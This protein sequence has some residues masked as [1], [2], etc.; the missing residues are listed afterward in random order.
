MEGRGPGW[1]RRAG[2]LLGRARLPPAGRAGAAPAGQP[3]L[4]QTGASLT[5]GG[6]GGRGRGEPGEA[7][8]RPGRS[9]GLQWSR[10]PE[11]PEQQPRERRGLERLS[12]AR[13]GPPAPELGEPP[14]DEAEARRKAAEAAAQPRAGPSAAAA[15]RGSRARARGAGAWGEAR[16]SLR[17]A[18]VGGHPRSLP[19]WGERPCPPPPAPS[20]AV[21]GHRVR[22]PRSRR[23]GRPGGPLPP[24]PRWQA[25]AHPPASPF[26][27][28]GKGS[29]TVAPF[30]ADEQ[31]PPVSSPGSYLEAGLLFLTV[32]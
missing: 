5:R 23:G 31:G 32:E 21:R 8:R 28:A 16:D 2:S 17:A 25:G 7:E 3:Q 13:P 27:A 30:P 10:S 24:P 29:L 12:A 18:G 20:A 22:Q 1:S 14:G 4:P 19:G 15:S 6:G 26:P 11:Q 9:R